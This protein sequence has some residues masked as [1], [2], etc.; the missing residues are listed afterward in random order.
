M[1]RYLLFQLYAPM[2]SWGAPAVGEV[3]HT[4]V[5]PTR[6]ALLGLLAAALGIPR[7]NEDE[8]NQF[9]QHYRFAILPLSSCEQWLRDYHTTQVPR[10]NKCGVV[11]VSGLLEGTKNSPRSLVNRGMR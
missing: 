3:R 6:S 8:L 2:A 5:I 1:S 10:E 11:I 9:N 4:D 7:D